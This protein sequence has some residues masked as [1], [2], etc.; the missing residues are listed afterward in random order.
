MFSIVQL[1]ICLDLLH[2]PEIAVFAFK[3]NAAT[4]W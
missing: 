4:T 1:C 2:K 3:H